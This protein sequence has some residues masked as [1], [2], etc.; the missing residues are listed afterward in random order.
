MGLYKWI[1]GEEN[2]TDSYIGKHGEFDEADRERGICEDIYADRYADH[3]FNGKSEYGWEHDMKYGS[4]GYED[5][6]DW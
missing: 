1:F 2:M 4:D 3:R 6:E 5:E